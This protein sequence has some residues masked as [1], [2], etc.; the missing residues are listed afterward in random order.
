MQSLQFHCI[1]LPA[2]IFLHWTSS[3]SKFPFIYKFFAKS[4]SWIRWIR[5][6]SE[7]FFRKKSQKIN[8][9]L[10]IELKS[11]T[12]LFLKTGDKKFSRPQ[13]ALAGNWVCLQGHQSRR[14]ITPQPAF[15][16]L[17]L[18]RDWFSILKNLEKLFSH[19]QT[20]LKYFL[21]YLIT[22]YWF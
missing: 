12:K 1:N 9:L 6:K 4:V 10:A 2:I 16:T 15:P 14:K 7:N 20:Q 3:W 5:I 18:F 22:K 19:L 8:W 13:R 21:K 11:R 17:S